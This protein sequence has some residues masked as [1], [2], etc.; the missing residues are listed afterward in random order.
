METLKKYCTTLSDIGSNL[1]DMLTKRYFKMCTLMLGI[2]S[3][4]IYIFGTVG[5][6]SLKPINIVHEKEDNANHLSTESIDQGL[7]WMMDSTKYANSNKGYVLRYINK[8]SIPAEQKMDMKRQLHEARSRTKKLMTN[9]A[10]GSGD[11]TIKYLS[12]EFQRRLPKGMIIGCKKCGTT[13]LTS[14]LRQ[15][16]GLAM[17]GELHYFDRNEIVSRQDYEAYRSK[18][19]NSFPDQIT[20]EKTPKYW[21]TPSAPQ[22]IHT[23]NPTIKLILLVR[24]PACRMA[25]DYH[26]SIQLQKD[27]IN[28]TVSFPDIVTK[29]QYKQDYDFLINPSL[30]DVHMKNWLLTFPLEQ[31]TIIKNEDMSTLKLTRILFE[32]EEYLGLKHELDVTG[33]ATEICI[34][35][36]IGLNNT[37]FNVHENGTCKYDAQYGDVL[38]NLRQVLQP[39]V[40]KFEE[41]VGR[42]FGWY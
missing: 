39:H 6:Q 4:L 41:I 5:Y 25:S 34:K 12:R 31:I 20:M 27:F 24:E 16:S 8:L 33:T 2:A 13:F 11:K 29:P 15:H 18:M 17:C 37:C 35:N 10:L 9:L 3:G 1:L 7:Q 14:I 28:K 30:Y 42:K 21:V 38:Q 40:I 32:V 19:Q 23:M 36:Q 26:H 22:G